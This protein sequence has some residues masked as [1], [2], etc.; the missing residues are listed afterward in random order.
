LTL[1][2]LPVK[3]QTF[4][5]F[6]VVIASGTQ[7]SAATLMLV[8]SIKF[9]PAPFTKGENGLIFIYPFVGFM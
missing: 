8:F 9:F 7:W 5:I 2:S 1:K 3:G 6:T 4:C